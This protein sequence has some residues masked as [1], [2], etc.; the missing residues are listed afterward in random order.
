[1]KL[2]SRLSIELKS[3]LLCYKLWS[4]P[5]TI[6]MTFIFGLG[7]CYLLVL[8]KILA[9]KYIFDDKLVVFKVLKH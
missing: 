4:K 1:M 7:L 8:S 2:K 9:I 3:R 5:K 6:T